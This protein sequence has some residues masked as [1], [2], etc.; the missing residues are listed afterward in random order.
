M[1]SLRTED[2]LE[3]LPADPR[4]WRD[5][6]IVASPLGVVAVVKDHRVRTPYAAGSFCTKEPRRS[7]P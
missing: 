6:T 3:V 5:V 4:D 1:L 2:T 7:A